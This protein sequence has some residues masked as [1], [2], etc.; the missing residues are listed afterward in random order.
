MPATRHPEIRPPKRK[1]GSYEIHGFGVPGPKL[2]PER[3]L[4]GL[5]VTSGEMKKYPMLLKLAAKKDF[6]LEALRAVLKKIR[7]REAKILRK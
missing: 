3:R 7:S 2:S 5:G 4:A 6:S 1:H